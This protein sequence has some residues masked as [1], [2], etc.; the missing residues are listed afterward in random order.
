MMD[1]TIDTTSNDEE[2]NLREGEM[3]QWLRYFGA[4]EDEP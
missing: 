3:D 1:D 4:D 2:P